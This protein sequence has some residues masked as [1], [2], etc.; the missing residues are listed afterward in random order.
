[1]AF[2]GEPSGLESVNEVYLG[3]D[4][5]S[6]QSAGVLDAGTRAGN[7]RGRLGDKAH[8][9]LGARAGASGILCLHND[10]DGVVL[11][12]PA[13]GGVRAGPLAGVRGLVGVLAPGSRRGVRWNQ[14]GCCGSVGHWLS[15]LCSPARWQS[16]Q[17][18]FLS[19]PLESCS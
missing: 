8:T 3:L 10:A 1:M 2:G 15:P 4:S 19:F 17:G 9:P 7:G 18:G 14:W 12:P 5:L 11:K 6:L 13:A 16:P